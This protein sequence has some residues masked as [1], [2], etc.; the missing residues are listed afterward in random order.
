MS[1]TF[2]ENEPKLVSD[3]IDVVEVVQSFMEQKR[4]TVD[5]F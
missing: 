3:R 1:E 2:P 4:R 5:G